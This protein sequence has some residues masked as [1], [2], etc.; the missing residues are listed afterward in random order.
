MSNAILI[1]GNSGTGKSTSI[2]T[3]PPE[4][5]FI[6]NV[7]DKPLPFRGARNKYSVQTKEKKGNCYSSNKSPNIIAAIDNID[8]ERKE[9][10]YLVIDDFSY[11]I[12]HDFMSKAMAKGFDK[13]N[14]IALST[15]NILDKIKHVRND[16]L[17]FIMMHSD[18]KE[19]GISKPKTIGRMLDDKVCIEGLFTHVLHSIV[20]DGEY[21]FI[22]NHDG[23]HM[24]KM[25]MG[26]FDSL[27]VNNDLKMISDSINRYYDEDVTLWKFM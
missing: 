25:P 3:L 24:A 16:L 21:K 11:V 7:L 1:I 22:T 10:K 13:F 19:D 18:V 6:I 17:I 4:E 23:V 2:R 27:L 5:T 20:V 15:Y 8:K 9:I 14:E 12:T 26:M